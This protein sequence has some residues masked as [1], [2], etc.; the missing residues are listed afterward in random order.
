M[1]R[2]SIFA[3]VLLLGIVSVG[4]YTTSKNTMYFKINKSL[5]I[6]GELFRQLSN[7]YVDEID[8]QEFVEAGIEGMLRHLDP[9]TVFIDDDDRDE[10]DILTT[11][12]YGGLGITTSII[13]SA[14]TI[15]A[16]NEGSPAERTGLRIGDKIFSIDSSIVLHT[17]GNDLR[18]FTRGKPGTQV[19]VKIL[20]EGRK[21]TLAFP[22]IRQEV[23]LKNVTFSGFVQS[24]IAYIR[25]ERFTHSATN[26]V[27]DALTLLRKKNPAIKG[28][29][30]DVRDNPGGLLEAAAGI[31]EFFVPSG[32]LIVTTKGRIDDNQRQYFS[33]RQ[34]LEPT[35][36][37]AILINDQ[38]ASASEIVAGAIQDLDRGVLVGERSFGKGLVQTISSLPYNATLKMTTAKYYTPSGRCIQKIDYRQ[39]RHGI[40][41]VS[42]DTTKIFRTINRRIVREATG[43]APDTTVLLPV[44]SPVIKNLI[45]RQHVF[46]FANEFASRFDILPNHLDL[47]KAA[48]QDFLTYLKRKGITLNN[49]ALQ[50]M[51]ELTAL[52]QSKQVQVTTMGKLQAVRGQ[53][54]QDYLRDVERHRE[55]I[56]T[57]VYEEIVQRFLS[58]SQMIGELLQSD[59]Q[60]QTAVTILQSPTRYKGILAQQ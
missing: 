30:L 6:F 59:R 27:H 31:T 14:V 41:K 25:L 38:S 29:I 45:N 18:R 5:Q 19:V 22:I 40:V 10:V 4:F 42:Q 2:I 8:P 9:Y 36:P 1:K 11:G 21:D 43:I 57:I 52:I 54:L 50:K 12:V 49:P 24:D 17:Q 35:L 44:D 34:P 15:V 20:R 3:I 39:R 26:E 46:H 48:Y 58:R 56:T 32:S 51:D 55:T 53:L 37:L 23:T 7:E 16:M 28:W 47:K 33:R 60:V 13:D